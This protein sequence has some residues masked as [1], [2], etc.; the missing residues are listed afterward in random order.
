METDVTSCLPPCC[1]QDRSE[2]P[3]KNFQ[4]C[5]SFHFLFQLPSYLPA[6]PPLLKG[7]S[8]SSLEYTLSLLTTHR[9]VLGITFFLTTHCFCIQ[10]HTLDA[11]TAM[12]AARWQQRKPRS[13]Q[14]AAVGGL[15]DSWHE[16]LQHPLWAG[17]A[18]PFCP[19]L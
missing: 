9:H 19:V 12:T 11:H 7:H 5:S 18:P 1:V 13:K 4:N 6:F 17:L 14:A 16:V 2:L 8:L 15:D 10:P 3:G